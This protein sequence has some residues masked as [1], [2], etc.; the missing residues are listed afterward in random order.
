MVPFS[1]EIQLAVALR[2]LAGASH[3]DVA[4]MF[5]LGLPTVHQTLWLVIDAINRTP[6]AGRFF[7]QNEYDCRGHAARYKVRGTAA[8]SAAFAV[9]FSQAFCAS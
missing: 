6:E 8:R 2:I 4:V 1:V 5:G 3:L 9:Y 7:P